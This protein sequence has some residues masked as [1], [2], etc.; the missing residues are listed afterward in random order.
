MIFRSESQNSSELSPG[1]PAIK[2]VLMMENPI[3][4]AS[5]YARTKSSALC[6]LPTRAS[7]LSQSVC[8]LMQI[9][10]TPHC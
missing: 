9:L 3:F 10:R 1:R 7:V 8:G 4:F 6:L 2:S 5:S